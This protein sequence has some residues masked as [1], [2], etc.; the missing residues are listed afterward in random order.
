V[1]GTSPPARFFDAFPR[2]Y[3]TGNTGAGVRLNARY[4]CL[5]QRHGEHLRGRKVLDVGSHNGRW[6][7]AALCAGARHVIGVEPRAA[8][9][10]ASK[11][12]FQEYGI[13]PD[14]F[15]FHV[16]DGLEFL[17]AARPKV[18]V[19]LLF[20]V[21]YHVHYH[22]PLLQQLRETSARHLI[23]DTAI[24]PDRALVHR[25]D[26]ILRL[27][28]EPVDDISNA[29]EEIISGA[30]SSVVGIPSRAAVTFLLETLGFEASEIS[31]APYF[32]RWGADELKD[33]AQGERTTFLARR[34]G[35]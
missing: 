21:L 5:I 27:I 33:Y 25:D 4:D 24:V 16:A 2:F 1:Q 3:E 6:S 32:N 14:R 18:E 26:Q 11:Q 23:I 12:V 9:V 29:A 19:V 7:F 20:G 22:V 28:A 31:W 34:R 35:T 17:R 30:G 15:E 10:K 8:L 13:A